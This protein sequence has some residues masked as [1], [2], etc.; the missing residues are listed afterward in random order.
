MDKE[1]SLHA[2]MLSELPLVGD[3][4]AARILEI[5]RR[6]SH[7]LGTFFRLPDAVLRDDYK[8]AARTVARVCAERAAHEHRCQWLVDQVVQAGGMIWSLEDVDYPERLRL[9]LQPPATVL[10]GFGNP[11]VLTPPTLAVLNSRTLTEQAVSASL[12]SVQSA[13][14]QGFALVGGGMKA[15]YRITAVAGR[16]AAAPRVIVLDRGLFASFGARLDRDPFGFGPGRAPLDIERT[17]VL[18]PFRLMDHA[19]AH[20][21]KRRDATVAALADVVVAVHARPGGEIEHVCLGALDR[22]QTV[23]SWYGENPG[24]VAAG[25]TPIQEADLQ[26]LRRF[27]PAC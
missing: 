7:T 24:L 13:A 12:L 1:S 22:G 4:A 17:L 10:F 18:S 26:N 20:N 14:A 19:V 27:V 2:V 3:K 16:A 15:T 23:L 6:R 8:L 5:N 11:A 21:G 25:A 9:R